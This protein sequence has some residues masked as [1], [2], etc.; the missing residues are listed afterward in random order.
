MLKTFS[1]FSL[2][3]PSPDNNKAGELMGGYNGR[4]KNGNARRKL[5]ERVKAEGRP[6][7]ICGQPIDYSL[8]AG[9]PLSYELDEIIPFSRGGSPIDYNNVQPAHRICNQ[10]RGNTICIERK[11]TKWDIKREEEA[12]KMIPIMKA[13]GIW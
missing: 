4:Y 12:K 8:P 11:K 2:V 9:H 10:R 7:G 13:V 3:S 5:R 6:C 1:P